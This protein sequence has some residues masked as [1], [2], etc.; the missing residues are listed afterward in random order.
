MNAVSQIINC[1]INLDQFAALSN[2]RD[3]YLIVS[4]LDQWK[5]VDYAIDAFNRM[6]LPLRIVGTG[7]C[8]SQLKSMAK[9]NITFVGQVTTDAALAREY[10]QAIAVVS[11]PAP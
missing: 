5:R 2:R 6:G 7:E 8:E 10:S 3:Y 1:P 11:H 4:R 9:S